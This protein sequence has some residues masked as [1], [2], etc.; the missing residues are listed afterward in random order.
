MGSIGILVL[1]ILGII[2]FILG[3]KKQNTKIKRIGIILILFA[4]AVGVPSLVKGFKDG[5][6]SGLNN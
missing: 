5:F 4:I 2:L 6:M 3:N 1:L